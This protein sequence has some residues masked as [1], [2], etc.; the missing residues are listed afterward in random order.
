MSFESRII[1][2]E[3]EVKGRGTSDLKSETG[4][5]IQE[6][7]K[8]VY[9]IFKHMWHADRPDA[10][11]DFVYV[12]AIYEWAQINYLDWLGDTVNG[13][14][15][16]FQAYKERIFEALD[17][18]AVRCLL[19]YLTDENN[20]RKVDVPPIRDPQIRQLLRHL[21]PESRCLAGPNPAGGYSKPGPE[22]VRKRAETVY[23]EI[24]EEEGR[25]FGLWTPLLSLIGKMQLSVYKAMLARDAEAPKPSAVWFLPD[26]VLRWVL[27]A[28]EG[29][30]EEG[31]PNRIHNWNAMIK[32]NDEAARAGK[33]PVLN[34]YLGDGTGVRVVTFLA[35]GIPMAMKCNYSELG[36]P[37]GT[38]PPWA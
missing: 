24:G 23:D 10:V 29:A 35:L 1:S 33:D 20:A 9:E 12:S 6:W 13:S 2:V 37:K 30:T 31:R 5:S 38:R 4:R 22:P 14:F 26:P 11:R 3:T 34:F 25:E 17:D 15:G 28:F 7:R 18:P 19:R 27:M 32:S 36:I 16:D 21:D 8:F